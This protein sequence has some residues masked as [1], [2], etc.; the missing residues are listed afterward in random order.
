MFVPMLAGGDMQM[1]TGVGGEHT[2]NE[3]K[4]WKNHLSTQVLKGT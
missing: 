2:L 3:K 1:S 4:N